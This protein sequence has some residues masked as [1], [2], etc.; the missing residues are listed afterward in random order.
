M[1]RRLRLVGWTGFVARLPDDARLMREC[2]DDMAA[3]H[4][5]AAPWV[6]YA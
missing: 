6:E 5:E 4:P 1:P 3:E 2:M